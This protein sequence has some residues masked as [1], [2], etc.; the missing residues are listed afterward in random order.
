MLSAVVIMGLSIMATSCSTVTGMFG[1]SS[2]KE[3]N[4]ADKIQSL[5]KQKEKNNGAKIE[6]IS[7]LS[8]GTTYALGKVTNNEPAIAVAYD[9]NKRIESLAGKPDLDVEKEMWKTVDQLLSQINAER[10]KGL[11]ALEK[12]DTEITAL[13]DE[14]KTIL[15][16]KET[17]LAKYMKLASDTAL[18]A[19]TRKAQLDEY[20]KWFGL[21]AIVKGF[22]QLISTSLWVI[23]G[24]SIA[25]IILRLASTAS[26]VAASLFGIFE[27]AVSWVINT[28]AVLFPKA[29]T[30]AGHVTRDAFDASQTLLKKIVDNLQNLKNIQSKLGHDMT[31]KELFVEL[32]KAMDSN[33]KQV[34]DKIKKELGY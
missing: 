8:S 7:I 15:S 3:S 1:K 11:K 21:G 19:D 31:L 20:T 29:L 13:Q 14:T 23:V 25:F 32:D 17:E 4:L 27:H 30:I 9:L 16:K 18:I 33:E 5:D 34:I 6:Q 28:I 26:P 22:G 12:K 24:I 2:V 10:N